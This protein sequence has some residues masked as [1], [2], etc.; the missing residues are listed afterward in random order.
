LDIRSWTCPILEDGVHFH[1]LEVRGK[2]WPVE[3][4]DLILDFCEESVRALMTASSNGRP[5]MI[6]S[7]GA[8]K[9]REL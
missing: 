5:V 9:I 6:S 1:W 4:S 3:A 2:S 7:P 8:S